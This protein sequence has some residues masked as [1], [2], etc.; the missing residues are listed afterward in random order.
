[1][2]PFIDSDKK[3]EDF[4]NLIELVRLKEIDQPSSGESFEQ[5][6][7]NKEP[8]Q[9]CLTDPPRVVKSVSFDEDRDECYP[10]RYHSY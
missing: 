10:F 7:F 3:L 6:S 2:G 1:M 9:D 4:K 8:S 5:S